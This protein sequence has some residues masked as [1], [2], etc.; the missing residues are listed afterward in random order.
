MCYLQ[1]GSVFHGHRGLGWSTDAELT[2]AIA[3]VHVLYKIAFTSVSLPK[4]GGK[5]VQ[6]KQ[7]RLQEQNSVYFI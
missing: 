1:M 4:I 5:R 2:G 6:L 7:A 3:M